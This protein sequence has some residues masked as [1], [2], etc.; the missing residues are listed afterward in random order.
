[1]YIW[2]LNVVIAN[3]VFMRIQRA[4]EVGVGAGAVWQCNDPLP[5][6]TA[7]LL[8]C[9]HLNTYHHHRQWHD[10]IH[11]TSYIWETLS[12]VLLEIVSIVVNSGRGSSHNIK[13]GPW[14][15][16]SVPCIQHSWTTKSPIRVQE[17]TWD[18]IECIHSDVYVVADVVQLSL[19]CSALNCAAAETDNTVTQHNTTGEYADQSRTFT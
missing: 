13:V 5:T 4:P 1:M 14:L 12:Y 6:A 2:V 3:Y 10:M 17:D 15:S 19:C 18:D 16:K 8:S 9:C 11:L 7:S